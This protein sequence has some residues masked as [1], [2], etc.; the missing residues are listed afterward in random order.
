MFARIW[1]TEPDKDWKVIAQSKQEQRRKRLPIK[2][3]IDPNQ[4]PN[5]TVLDVTG[6]CDELRWLDKEELAI[7]DLS[8]VELVVAVKDRRYTASK[9]VQAFAHRATIAQQL[10]NA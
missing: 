7:T 6:I 10:V 2:W 4:L 3:T 9:V 1:G 8:V 5:E